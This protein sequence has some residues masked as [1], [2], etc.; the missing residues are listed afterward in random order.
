MTPLLKAAPLAQSP[1]GAWKAYPLSY[2]QERLWILD[3]I[4]PGT[5]AFNIATAFQISGDIQFDLL[6]TS[7]LALVAQHAAL[8]TTFSYRDGQPLQI[9]H[10]DLQPI[11]EFKTLAEL[12]SADPA[13]N[14]DAF[15]AGE[16]RIGF[17]L[18]A[19]PLF[20]ATLLQTAPDTHYLV[21][22]L[23][24]IVTDGWSNLL[25]Y[26]ELSKTYSALAVGD[27]L[28]Q[29][30]QAIDYPDFAVWQRSAEQDERVGRELEFWR[31]QLE[32]APQPDLPTDFPRPG[33]QTHNARLVRLAIT[34]EQTKAIRQR[35]S[36]QRATSFMILLAAFKLVLQR[37]SGQDDLVVGAPMAGRQRLETEKLVG[38]FL[39]SLAIRTTLQPEMTFAELIEK[40]R[41]NTLMAF[42]HQSIPFERLVNELKPERD[43]SRTPIFQVFFN[44][45]PI[46]QDPLSLG[47]AIGEAY[48][49][50]PYRSLFDL[51]IYIAPAEA[52]LALRFVYNPDLF[53]EGTIQALATQYQHV[54]DQVIQDPTRPLSAYDL[55]PREHKRQLP[56]PT[57]QLAGDWAGSMPDQLRAWAESQPQA[58]ALMAGGQSWDYA[59]LDAG[60]DRAAARL[61][62]DGVG[63]GSVI[64][65]YAARSPELVFAAYAVLRAG[66]AILML[67]P[68][69]P[70]ARLR[71]MV[72][73]AGVELLLVVGEPELP[74]DLIAGRR[75]CRVADLLDDSDPVSEPEPVTLAA[76]DLAV[77]GFTSG[78]TGQ[79]KGILGLHGS[80]THF[81]PWMVEHF[82]LSPQDRFSSLSGLAHDPLQRELFTSIWCGGTL[83]FPDPMALDRPQL[84]GDW[85]AAAKISFAHLTPAMGQLL[86]D[87]ASDGLT[88]PDLANIYYVGDRLT[89]QHV[90]EIRALAPNV[91]IWNGYGSTETQRAVAMHQVPAHSDQ[92]VSAVLPLGQ[93]IP[94][95]QLLIRNRSGAEAGIGELGEILVR[96]PHLAAGYLHDPD[97]TAARFSA[98]EGQSRLY[99]T[100]DLGRYDA[101]GLVVFAG[102]GDR[103]VKV[104]GFRIELAEIE[105]ALAEQPE[106]EVAIVTFTEAGD[107][108]G[109]LDAYLTTHDPAA[110]LSGIRRALRIRL[111]DYMVPA[112]LIRVEQIPLTPNGKTDLEALQS[113]Q[114][115]VEARSPNQSPQSE[116]EQKLAALWTG[117]LDLDTVSRTD[118][119]FDLGG[120]SL[121]AIRLFAGIA[122]EL[123]VDLPLSELFQA[124]TL[125]ELAEVVEQGSSPEQSNVVPI[126]PAGQRRPFFCV[127]GFGGGVI[128]YAELARQVGSD[129]PF[130]GLQAAGLA[131][132]QPPDEDVYTMASRYVQAMK[133]VQAEGPYLL[134]GYCF[135]G[136]VAFEMARQLESAGEQVDLLA[137][138]EGFAPLRG[139]QRETV[140]KN[141]RLVLNFFQNL[142]FWLRDFIGLGLPGMSARFSRQAS[143]YRTRL[144]RRLGYVD[145]VD[146]RQI[147]DDDVEFV[148]DVH[149]RLM[150]IHVR[151]MGQYTPGTYM[152]E[153]TLFRVAARSIFRSP[154]PHNGWGQLTSHGVQL[155]RIA[156]RHQ[157]ILEPPHVGSLAR[158][159]KAALDDAAP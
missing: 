95:A 64:A 132:N 92:R 70:V 54:L 4:E 72:E 75:S 88:L 133:H 90:D 53:A 36:S 34:P 7:L 51:T 140:W 73:Q 78:S 118:N 128:G 158:A 41:W 63:P 144:R 62:Q 159:L 122:H 148:P 142:P 46:A 145:D 32:G 76:D 84:L 18:V 138:F 31:E 42:D 33:V 110:N 139:D 48:P 107:A 94:G 25:L 113:L 146:L 87:S 130:Y 104:R 114:T 40:L 74:E 8:R 47:E 153:I 83:C 61:Q 55:R 5:A 102:R 60:V 2:S 66:A 143:R 93:G 96:S 135:G 91:Q 30:A 58:T 37:W 77:I 89:H 99:H 154:D 149:R 108:G 105:T 6:R 131:D 117:L 79:P 151:A 126:Q 80:L 24:H 155:H 137:V 123:G 38:F 65:I 15:L 20:R 82:K 57:V 141:P 45:L 101:N 121:L 147:I 17:N 56:D 98:G 116:T 71:T 13:A 67:D 22:C 68:A 119:F 97:L 12:Q 115:P 109:R 27:P 112:R 125:A 129:R 156:G 11:I 124:P 127:H 44:M 10:T 21:F 49:M 152:D 134:G 28:P 29:E 52:G 150:Q 106:I 111:P 81:N 23:H 1:D 43:L 136:V 35:G 59:T 50:A 120:H 103:Q 86:T 85:M 39:N 19:G 157:N 69:Y 100:G 26:Q 9:V 3:Q 16:A 14:V